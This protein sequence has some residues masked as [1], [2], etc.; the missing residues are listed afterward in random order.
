MSNRLDATKRQLSVESL[1][2]R[3]VFSGVPLAAT[4]EMYVAGEA[5][6]IPEN[7]GVYSNG[8]R[9]VV[10]TSDS[11][12]S[13]RFS[14]DSEATLGDLFDIWRLNAGIAGNDAD[15]H[16]DDEQLL[17]HRAE[18]R[19]SVR[20]FVNG[21]VNRQY[22]DYVIQDGD[23]I[24]VAYSANP[25]VSMNTNLG[26][27]LIE[28]YPNRTPIT[29]DNFLN[30]VNDGDYDQSVFHRSVPGFV[31]Q[32]GG[33]HTDSNMV[34]S[35][36]QFSRIP[37]DRP[38]VN[39]PGISNLRGTVGM[40]KTSNPDSATSQFFVNL[41]D[42]SSLDHPNNS[43]GFTVFADVL[44]MATVDHIG[45]LDVH[46]GLP[47]PFGELPVTT[48]SELVVIEGVVGHG[49][50]VGKKYLDSNENGFQDA[51]EL[52]IANALIYVDSN[53]NGML[54]DGEFTAKT[55]DDGT[56]RLVVEP[57]EY[58][59]RSEPTP[60]TEL[61]SGDNGYQATVEI[62][63]ETPGLVFGETSGDPKRWQNSTDKYDINGDGRRSFKDLLATIQYF[64]AHGFGEIDRLFQ[65]APYVD[66]DGNGRA[67]TLDLALLVYGLIISPG[68]GGEA[69]SESS[70]EQ[71]NTPYQV[72]PIEIETEELWERERAVD[73]I[74][75]ELP[76]V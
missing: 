56:F 4:L 76:A 47:S 12:G 25:I 29:V 67:Q 11:T 9:A 70:L 33:F 31:V 27:I 50:L 45:T 71:A 30:Y 2:S 18:G 64:R 6:Q 62:G 5:Q 68:P 75:A 35:S 1:E 58:S 69:M 38:I 39:E 52:G 26:S 8:E 54:D 37:A 22:E 51:G 60:T 42:N 20:M 28:L 53:R 34:V 73:A 7:I 57:G 48:E 10:S 74:F 61:T 59:V 13:L 41:G 43:G 63:R 36:G 24:A 72:P 23:H 21:Q 17:S 65:P 46:G 15:A 19:H 44:N 66:V 49:E 32:G 14:S 16:F 55:R 3:V 40:A